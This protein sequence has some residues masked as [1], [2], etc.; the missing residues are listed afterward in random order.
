MRYS[1]FF[2]SKKKALSPLQEE[3]LKG[4]SYYVAPYKLSRSTGET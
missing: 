2:F 1:Q 3:G 4:K